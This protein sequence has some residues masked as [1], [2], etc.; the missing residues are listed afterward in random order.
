MST[1]AVSSAA[2]AASTSLSSVKLRRSS[3]AS[4][5]PTPLRRSLPCKVSSSSPSRSPLVPVSANASPTSAGETASRKKLL[6]FDAEEDLVASLADYVAELSAKFTAE[7]GAFTVVLSG[8]SL[9]KTLRKLAEPPYL[10]AVDWSKW[11][12]FWVDERV[13]PKNHVDSNYKLALDGKLAEPPYLEAVD[14]SKWHVFWVDERVVPKDHVDSNY[15]LAFDG[16]LSKVSI[17]AGQVYAINDALSAEGASEDYETRLKQLVKNGV[18]E[19]SPV[20][21]F[22]KFDLML[23]GMGPD[24]HVA[25]LFP[26]HPVVNENKKWVAFVKDSPKPPP[27]RITFTLPVINSSAHIALVV[28]GAGKAGAVHKALSDQHNTTDLLPVEMVSLQDGELTWFTD[29]PAVCGLMKTAASSA[30]IKTPKVAAR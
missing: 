9:V 25:S 28:T 7:R 11:H 30:Y 14:W 13:V 5:V 16:F 19:I 10:E 23:M 26:G 27:E 24:G 29:K 1:S 8:G 15:K 22:P 20:T 12:V 18:I 2:A 6:I 17:P 3:P 21:G 4:S